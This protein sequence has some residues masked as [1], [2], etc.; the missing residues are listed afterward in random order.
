M[1]MLVEW[2]LFNI[3]LSD[4]LL[5]QDMHAQEQQYRPP[6]IPPPPL[7][8]PSSPALSSS[9]FDTNDSIK[10]QN[11]RHEIASEKRDDVSVLS[12]KSVRSNSWIATLDVE[13]LKAATRQAMLS[14]RA[15]QRD[16]TIL[17]EA[18]LSKLKSEESAYECTPK[19][20]IARLT[21]LRLFLLSQWIARADVILFESSP[22][23]ATISLCQDIS[24][25]LY[26]SL[27]K[28]CDKV[29]STYAKGH[30]HI[31]AL[32]LATIHRLFSLVYPLTRSRFSTNR[33]LSFQALT[34]A[35][36]VLADT[37][38]RPAQARYICRKLLLR[39]R[40]VSLLRLSSQEESG[41]FW[42]LAVET[43]TTLIQ[44]GV[45]RPY[46]VDSSQKDCDVDVFLCL[47]CHAITN[48]Q[49]HE[50]L[51][52]AA[53]L[54]IVHTIQHSNFQRS[55]ERLP[56]TSTVGTSSSEQQ[57]TDSL[58]LQP[59]ASAVT[60][61]EMTKVLTMPGRYLLARE[62]VFMAP[63]EQ[64][65]IRVLTFLMRKWSNVPP[66]FSPSEMLDRQR[67]EDMHSH[68]KC[69]I[70][71]RL[72]VEAMLLLDANDARYRDKLHSIFIAR[73]SSHAR[74]RTPGL[75]MA[76]LKALGELSPGKSSPLEALLL[77]HPKAQ[78]DAIRAFTRAGK[79][80][81]GK[82]LAQSLLV[83]IE[84]KNIHR[85]NPQPESLK[86]LGTRIINV[87]LVAYFRLKL[88]NKVKS[89]RKIALMLRRGGLVKAQKSV[90][91]QTINR[92]LQG[93]RAMVLR[94]YYRHS[95]VKNRQSQLEWAMSFLQGFTSRHGI[96]PNEQTSIIILSAIL[97]MSSYKVS[98]E[99]LQQAK[100]LVW[101]WTCRGVTRT[102]DELRRV[103]DG[104][105]VET[106]A[107]QDV[108]TGPFHDRM[109]LM[110]DSAI[111]ERRRRSM[112]DG[113][114]ESNGRKK[115]ARQS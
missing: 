42:E 93:K 8:L 49:V 11:I 81:K 6:P 45:V 72:W 27:S 68:R 95:H 5:K 89:R 78:L 100:S 103:L 14:V 10:A 2:K 96:V 92:Y 90:P 57:Q 34:I 37:H 97:R 40:E 48:N 83:A 105:R 61:E 16:L 30:K 98:D 111:E 109:R 91:G 63:I 66:D 88:R 23:P 104:T 38:I 84:E 80:A 36:K 13:F 44:S 59:F 47:L 33:N 35:T 19:E 110:I 43:I 1:Q 12:G 69:K 73:L 46:D 41:P 26:Q 108:R 62:I 7:L 39:M 55:T 99:K 64:R 75:V 70:S 115:R 52:R 22:T 67:R 20:E 31:R 4:E 77:L 94:R 60:L 101:D 25:Q 65:R 56:R 29:L 71:Q 85:S 18:V 114:H 76:D 107:R 3:R 50:N 86:D 54:K 28:N 17:A 58:H 87:L 82:K 24:L 32:H 51:A 79:L 21:E 102:L 113:T 15:G 106:E 53:V 112:S 9:F 74:S